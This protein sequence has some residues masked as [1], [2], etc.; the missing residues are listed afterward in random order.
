MKQMEKITLNYPLFD[1]EKIIENTSVTLENGTITAVEAS[2]AIDTTHFLMPA[3]I[4]AHTH[5]TTREHVTAMLKNGVAAACDVAAPA[6]LIESASPF[7]IVSSAGMT[8]G[9]LNGKAYVKKAIQAGAAYIKVLLMEPNL[10]P[11]CA[12][13]E[14]CQTAHENNLKVAVHAVSV[15]AVQM[16]V[17]CGADILIHVPMKQVFPEQL[18]IAIS[19]KGIV[20]APTLVM[21]EAFAHSDRNG[22][23]PEHFKNA[24]DAVR[25]LHKH[26]V[27][28]LAATD[29]NIGSFAPGVPYGTSL[30]REMKLLE[31][32]GM[33]P[34]EILA[35]ATGN[36]AK[37][38][39]MDDLGMIASG[40]KAALL[41]LEG[42]PDQ[43]ITDTT[44]IKQIWIDGQPI[45]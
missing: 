39:G 43:N 44:K 40:K 15:K 38:F 10:M 28:I 21:M 27:T 26:G 7:R 17:D 8:M 30:H 37:T 41:L 13:K 12:L 22:Y 23:K 42:R 14:I 5:I 25:L 3:L 11:K 24:E 36:I 16:C 34:I 32:A 31:Q 20:L 6:S 19:E 1:G 35:S 29:A 45:L 4:D 9:T 33:S 2:D 18:A